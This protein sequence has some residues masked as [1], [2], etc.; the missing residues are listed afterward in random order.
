MDTSINKVIRMS[1]KEMEWM[2]I[3]NRFKLP[4]SSRTTITNIIKINSMM[5]KINRDKC[6][7]WIIKI[8]MFRIKIINNKTKIKT[9]TRTKIS[10]T[11]TKMTRIKNNKPSK[12]I[13]VKITNSTKIINR[14]NNNTNSNLLTSI[15]VAN[16]H[17]P[18]H[19]N[20]SNRTIKFNLTLLLM[21]LHLTASRA[22]MITTQIKIMI[23]RSNNHKMLIMDLLKVKN[24]TKVKIWL[25]IMK[26]KIL[27]Q[28]I[29]ITIT[30]TK[31]IKIIK[32]VKMGNKVQIK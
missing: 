2:Q 7:T 30:T 10:I 20:S 17:L 27:I 6:K 19:N 1:I 24:Q 28:T 23:I 29:R 9:K 13:K 14:S 11:I 3:I 8:I 31:I 5:T 16:K 18:N 22:R 4:T 26:R 12:I 32:M 25:S 15:K 21:D